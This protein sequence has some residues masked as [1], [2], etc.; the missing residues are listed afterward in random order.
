[1]YEQKNM[2]R[3]KKSLSL[4]CDFL[5]FTTKSTQYDYVNYAMINYCDNKNPKKSCPYTIDKNINGEHSMEISKAYDEK[6]EHNDSDCVLTLSNLAKI[7]N[8]SET[9]AIN[10]LERYRNNYPEKTILKEY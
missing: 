1:M 6:C 5:F 8:T 3:K 2:P 10:L 7:F 9:S 4:Y